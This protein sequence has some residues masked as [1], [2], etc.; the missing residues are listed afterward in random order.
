MKH[1]VLILIIVSMKHFLLVA[2]VPDSTFGVPS[3]FD[4]P[5]FPFPAVTGCDFGGSEDRSFASLFLP[6]G[7]IILA[8]HSHDADGTDFTLV[9]LLPDGKFDT[10]AGPEGQ[11]RIDL[12]YQN[13]SCL[14]AA[15]YSTDMVV[16]GGC[17]TLPGQNGY[18]L[19]IARV[20]IGGQADPSFGDGGHTMVDLPTENEMVTKIIV[21]SDGKILLAGNAFFGH[22][23][24]SPD[25]TTVFVGRL[26][27]N[28]QVDST[29]GTDGFIYR[30]YEY[31]CKSSILYDVALDSEGRIVLSGGSYS[32]YPGSYYVD[33]WCTHN[34]HVCRYLPDGQP[35]PA[36]G[37][38]GM[39]ELPFS[40]GRTTTLYI[41]ADNRI[42]IGGVVTPT[43]LIPE[44]MF[45]FIARLMPDGTPDVS[46]ADNGR[47]VELVGAVTASSALIDVIKIQDCYY[48]GL[49]DQ[50]Y[51]DHAYFGLM[52]M[53]DNGTVDSTF[54]KDGVYTSQLWL[55]TSLYNT[56]HIYTIDSN[57]IYI[58][59]YYSKLSQDN[60]MI[61][62][63][64]FDKTTSLAEETGISG[65]GI[66][67]FPNPVRGEQVYFEYPDEI[68]EDAVLIQLTDL[69]G[70]LVLRQS[71]SP[72]GGVNALNLF[73]LQN[74]VY[75]VSFVGK[76]IRYVN[77]LV[78]QR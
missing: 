48:F 27:S 1:I 38:S 71:V 3:S 46:F 30:R 77:K 24:N 52:R 73:G 61:A 34:I 70:R 36:F 15:L 31:T 40:K 65:P 75:I 20:D 29:F 32:P 72:V 18:A 67:I 26:L 51:G 50:A 6:D 47:F 66:R 76:R 8:G 74:G 10:T 62:K 43:W 37:N 59:G 42:L 23:F 41:E 35:D 45:S 63:V 13:D 7:K 16:M 4:G 69:Q 21:L 54:G 57:S 64:K 12:G 33:D 5:S 9:R 17:V 53:R 55:P 14:A 78:I 28:G 19:L 56:N 25:S 68:T 58:S 22:S 11:M 2:Q 49:L 39:Q 60:M 44:P